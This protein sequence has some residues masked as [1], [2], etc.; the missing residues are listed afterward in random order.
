MGVS[1]GDERTRPDAADPGPA[2]GSPPSSRPA[3]DASRGVA[4]DLLG[5][6]GRVIAG[7]VVFV[8]YTIS[9]I[10]RGSVLPGLVGGALAGVLA[11]LLL[12]EA[13]DRR[14]RRHGS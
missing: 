13:E 2:A 3:G 1:P 9:F 5:R 11:F 4:G 8:L 7:L 6:R 12:R 14:R 10:L